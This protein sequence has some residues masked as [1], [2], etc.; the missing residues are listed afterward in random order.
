MSNKQAIEQQLNHIIENTDRLETIYSTSAQFFS[1]VSL[2]YELIDLI[3]K[4]NE[5][6]KNL[7]FSPPLFV[8]YSN[9]DS[10]ACFPFAE[11]L[12]RLHEATL[13]IREYTFSAESVHTQSLPIL[14]ENEERKPALSQ[15]FVS[16]KDFEVAPAKFNLPECNEVISGGFE[17]PVQTLVHLFYLIAKHLSNIQYRILHPDFSLVLRKEKEYTDLLIDTLEENKI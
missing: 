4:L 9:Q 14:M 15:F 5:E 16:K 1:M 12:E 2:S 8:D 7:F 17:G 13:H 10:M 6:E 11:Q 3:G